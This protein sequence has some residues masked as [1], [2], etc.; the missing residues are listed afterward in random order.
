MTLQEQNTFLSKE[1]AEA[2]RYMDNASE[3]LQR[4]NKE[5]GD[6]YYKDK[7]YVRSACGIAY[8]GVLVALDAWLE[9]KGVE[10]PKKKKNKSIEYYTSNLSQI[11]KKM[12]SRMDTVYNVLHLDGYYR[13][14]RRIKAI[15]AGFDA[16]YE[17]IEKIKPENPVEIVETR[18]EKVKHKLDR[19][20]MYLTVFFRI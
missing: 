7:K 15:Q 11:D 1:F 4:A 18:L 6:R 17:I 2:T 13:G 19:M 5:D 14:E 12:A 8:L 3:T 10:E 9:L 16:A 20:L